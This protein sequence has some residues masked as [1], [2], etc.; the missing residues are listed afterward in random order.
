MTL[1]LGVVA[2]RAST[3]MRLAT[4]ALR[5]R[6]AVAEMKPTRRRSGGKYGRR[7]VSGSYGP[8]T[9][10]LSVSLIRVPCLP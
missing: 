8:S 2:L 10:L 4:T 7:I 9:A 5:T 3:L 6:M 1:T